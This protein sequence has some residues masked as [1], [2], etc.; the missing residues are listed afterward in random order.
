MLNLNETS[1]IANRTPIQVDNKII[2]AVCTFQPVESI[3]KTEQRLRKELYS[4]GLVAHH[5]FN[6]IIG[7]SPQL[8]KLINRARLYAQTSST[9][10]LQGNRVRKELMAQS[11]HRSAIVKMSP[12]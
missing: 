5:N 4:K 6:D 11:I 1:V 9:I 3:L 12:L 10:L 2:G 8:K 7:D